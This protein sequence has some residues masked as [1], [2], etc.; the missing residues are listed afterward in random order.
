MG[1]PAR[2]ID[3]QI[4][5]G[6][7]LS[8][9]AADVLKGLTST[10]K[11]IPPKYFY[12]D[13]GSLLFERITE[14]PEYYPTRSELRI[15]RR[16][17]GDIAK[18]IPPGAALIEFG[19]GSSKKARIVL[20]G[21]P[22]LSVYVPVDICSEMIER[23]AAELRSD[24]PNLEILPVVADISKP[25]QIPAIAAAAPVRV[26]FFPGS[27]IGNF[28][29]HEA[30]SFLRNAAQILGRGA[31]LIVGVDL[32]KS[33]DVLH[34]AYNDQAGVTAAFNQNLL[35][36]I[37][38]ELGGTFKLDSF[39][40]HAFYNRERNRIEMHLASL[41]R[42]KVRVLG[43]TI[44]FR[45]GETIHTENSYK[46]SVASLGALA[47]GVGWMPV[48]SWLDSRKYFS[49]QVFRLA[50]AQQAAEA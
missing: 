28:E 5:R 9:F 27:T 42:Q 26:G 23:E 31:L 3:Q 47:R 48:A 45:A 44:D 19:S 43:Q 33:A 50:S 41:K 24:F 18:L 21:K 12:D 35:K 20:G 15:L 29:P 38:R 13:E 37:N 39:E 34:A 11:Q 30:A 8:P 40:H 32:I 14:L 7:E 36:R 22:A 16:H 10:P 46:Y 6:D 25:F 1:E 17:A 49:I 2:K 4:S